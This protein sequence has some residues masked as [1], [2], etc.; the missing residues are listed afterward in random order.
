[1]DGIL[2]GVHEKGTSHFD[3][4]GA[5]APAA[6]LDEALRHAEA[7]EYLGH[8]FGDAVLVLPRSLSATR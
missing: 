8:E 2:T 7:H 4:L 1:V 3:L 5:F 6:L